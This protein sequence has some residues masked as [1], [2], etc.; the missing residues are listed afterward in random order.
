MREGGVGE[1]KTNKLKGNEKGNNMIGRKRNEKK[2]KNK[3]IECWEW[4]K[5]WVKK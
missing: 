2:E 5:K 3:R 1:G 4:I